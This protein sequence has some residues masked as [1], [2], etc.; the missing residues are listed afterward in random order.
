MVNSVNDLFKIINL[1]TRHLGLLRLSLILPLLL[2][3]F[4]AASS[5]YLQGVFGGPSTLAG[6]LVR[7]RAA[8]GYWNK[9]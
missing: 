8:P 4:S 3:P 1:C 2:V 5:V 6:W 9:L 7:M